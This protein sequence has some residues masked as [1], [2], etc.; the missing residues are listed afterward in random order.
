ME[1]PKHENP[2]H[3]WQ[4]EDDD[5]LKKY[6]GIRNSYLCPDC[7]KIEKSWNDF[8]QFHSNAGAFTTT[9]KKKMFG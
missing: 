7:K 4:D 5:A 2:L 3:L 1:E 6:Y 9:P 8:L